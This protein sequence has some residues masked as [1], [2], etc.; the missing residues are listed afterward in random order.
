MGHESII[1]GY[2]KGSMLKGGTPRSYDLHPLNRAVIN[3]LPKTD[4]W[5]FFTRSMFS[6]PG[7]DVVSGRYRRQIIHFGASLKQ[8]ESD[9]EEWLSKFESLL[10][11]LYWQE[12]KLHLETELVGNHT[13]IWVGKFDMTN[14]YYQVYAPTTEWT[15]EG[16]P[17]HFDL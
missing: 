3:T 11:R 15:F 13:Y 10:K 1:Y 5:P 2:I 12:A 14:P 4:Q 17:R 6:Y 16:G 8:V 7:N 9:W